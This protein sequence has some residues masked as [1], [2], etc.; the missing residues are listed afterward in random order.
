MIKDS[1]SRKLSKEVGAGC[2]DSLLCSYLLDGGERTGE[3]KY[4]EDK[5][6]NKEL[7]ALGEGIR[8]FY[9]KPSKSDLPLRIEVLD[10]DVSRAASVICALSSI[11]ESFAYPAVLIEADMCAALE[12]A[13]L[14]SIEASLQTLSG[15]RPLR[16]NSRP[17]R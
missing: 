7:A 14:E 17:F 11:S 9:L 10:S 3:M 16:R 13:E 8:V 2:S 12:P 15:M 6:P 5:S 1:R 4:F